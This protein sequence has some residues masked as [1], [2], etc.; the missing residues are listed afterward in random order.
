MNF[1]VDNQLPVALSRFLT[2][3]GHSSDHVHGLGMDE[4]SDAE[5]WNFTTGRGLIL[6]SKDEDFLHLANRPDD[7]G[8]LLW[9]RIGNCRKP[10]LLDAFDKQL[11]QVVSA[12]T[13]GIRIVE[14]R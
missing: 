3:R 10:A 12:F 13:A 7:S 11:P 2:D 6:I 4:A 5:I 9:V 8:K 14:I 1:L